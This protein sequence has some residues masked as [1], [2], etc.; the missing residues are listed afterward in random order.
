ML[1]RIQARRET[2]KADR[3]AQA[4]RDGKA[5]WGCFDTGW[6]DWS[7]TY[8]RCPVGSERQSRDRMARVR[9]WLALVDGETGIPAR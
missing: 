9:S 7:D 1:A 3:E 2:F 5:C 8:C 6:Q 4:E